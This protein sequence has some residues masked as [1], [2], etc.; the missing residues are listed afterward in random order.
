MVP[1]PAGIYLSRNLSC[2]I[3]FGKKMQQNKQF[4]ILTVGWEL[5]LIKSMLTP[6]A[7]KTGIRFTHAL[8]GDAQRVQYFKREVPDV[9]FVAL[10]KLLVEP[11]PTPDVEFL[12]SFEGTG[13]PTICSMI[14]GD[15]VLK[16]RYE[17]EAL[18]YATLLARNILRQLELLNPDLVLGSFDSIHSSLSLAVSK[19]KNT[20]WAAMAFTVVPGGFTG[21]CKATTPESLIPL[22]GRVDQGLRYQAI[23][24]VQALRSKRQK[25]TAYKPPQGVKQR[26][27]QFIVYLRNFIQRVIDSK[28]KGIDRYTYP[29]VSERCSEILRRSLNTLSLPEKHMLKEPPKESFIFFPL[30]MTPESSIDTWA[31]VY[32]NQLA[33]ASQIAHALPINFTFVIKLHFSDPDNYSRRQILQLL[34]LP[35]VRVAHPNSE[36]RSFI[37]SAA[38]LVGIQGT[39]CLEAALLGKPVL[40]FGESPYQHFPRTERALRPDLLY[41]QI[42]RLVNSPVV[43]ESEIVESYARYLARYLPGRLNDWSR[44]F[45]ESE[46]ERLANCFLSLKKYSTDLNNRNNWYRESPFV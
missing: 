32:Q 23:E 2:R 37:E 3:I 9:D 15:R 38:L 25:V 14:Q 17:K 27:G 28:E 34:K 45:E 30:Q 20:P 5:P 41:D 6:I 8:V 4:H 13:I 42:V 12:K 43:S 22:N 33:L 44:P 40:I 29:T 19:S 11:L 21:F 16:N 46:L 1:Q 24:V 36:G 18:S 26:I 7:S 10:S 39:A 35:R 31:P